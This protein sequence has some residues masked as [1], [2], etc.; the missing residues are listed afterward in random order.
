MPGMAAATE[1]RSSRVLEGVPSS[2][3]HPVAELTKTGRIDPDGA[4]W[5]PEMPPELVAEFRGYRKAQVADEIQ[6]KDEL[7]D[8][9]FEFLSSHKVHGPWAEQLAF[10]EDTDEYYDVE[11]QVVEL[12]REW[13]YS[14]MEAIGEP[15]RSENSS[16]ST[17]E[18]KRRLMS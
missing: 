17:A 6:T 11:D 8:M 15:Y 2:Y 7:F 14:L 10:G 18:L 4:L 1:A 13:A 9:A 16:E 5:I 12:G 3:A